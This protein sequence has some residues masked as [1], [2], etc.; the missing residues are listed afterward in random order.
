MER[1]EPLVRLLSKLYNVFMTVQCLNCQVEFEKKLSEIKK[2][3]NHFCCRS[4]HISYQNRINP[5]RLLQGKCRRC[6]RSCPS[7][8]IF[9][10]VKCLEKYKIENPANTSYENV[11]T[12]RQRAKER[13]VNYLG[14]KCQNCGYNRS[15]RALSFHHY[16][17]AEKDFNISSQ[18]ISWEAMVKEL[19]KCVLVCSNCHME[20]H[21][22][23]LLLNENKK[24]RYF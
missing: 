21:D 4:C 22:G 14:G 8:R 16:N 6:Q 9:C 13:A 11:K 2:S 5:K 1:I 15:L 23:V 3:S 19:N 7:S 18:C 10:S 17:P 20:I 12:W 24:F